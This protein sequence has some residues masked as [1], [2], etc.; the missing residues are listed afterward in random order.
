[1][2]RWFSRGRNL[3]FSF[4][5]Q[6]LNDLSNH[7]LHSDG[8]CVQVSS[9]ERVHLALCCGSGCV[10]GTSPGAA[11]IGGGEWAPPSS[12]GA[13]GVYGAIP[14]VPSEATWRVCLWLMPAYPPHSLSPAARPLASDSSVTPNTPRSFTG[15]LKLHM[16]CGTGLQSRAVR[17]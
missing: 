10:Q 7:G 14:A 12:S 3:I 13:Q 6:H 8:P 11:T 2:P 4:R 9:T 15:S 17:T 5:R 1:M 16:R